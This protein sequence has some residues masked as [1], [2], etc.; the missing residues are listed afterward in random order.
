MAMTFAEARSMVDAARE[1][2][3]TLGIAYYRRTYP[4]VARAK[5]LLGEGVIG[6][7]LFAFVTNYELRSPAEVRRAWQFD[8]ALAGGG[9]LFDIGSHR[10][11]LLN[12]LFRRTAAGGG[13]VVKCGPRDGGGG[14]RHG[15]D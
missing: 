4:K 15:H 10:I 5:E 7:P 8:P 6:Q 3:K 1:A 14:L 2:G 11:D 12:Y 9:P 13:T